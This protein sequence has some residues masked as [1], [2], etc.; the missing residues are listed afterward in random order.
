MDSS[1]EVHS[2]SAIK[3]SQ[4]SVGHFPFSI[5][6]VRTDWSVCVSRRQIIIIMIRVKQCARRCS[7]AQKHTRDDHERLRAKLEIVVVK[8][9]AT[10]PD[11]SNT[12]IAF[13]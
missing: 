4:K 1:S 2:S 3:H 10:E 7:V 6:V 12:L 9:G 13:Y 11:G 5:M 8:K